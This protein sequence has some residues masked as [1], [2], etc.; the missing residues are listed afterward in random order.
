[1][2]FFAISDTHCAN[3]WPMPPLDDIALMIH[4]G[5]GTNSYD[6]FDS[7]LEMEYFLDRLSSIDIPH[8]VFV[9]GNHDR[10]VEFDYV[11]WKKRFKQAGCILLRDDACEIEGVKIY[12]S[13]WTPTF[14]NWA[15]MKSRTKINRIWEMIPE[16]TDILVTHGPPK[17]ILDRT[18]CFDTNKIISVGDGALAKRVKKV[19]PRFH[20]FGHVHSEPDCMNY[21]IYCEQQGLTTTYVNASVQTNNLRKKRNLGHVVNYASF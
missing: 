2:K 16:D 3:D 21:G 4:A 14:M 18:C 6:H 8:K 12:G 15:F 5:D 11:Y 7:R 10:C 1:M 9:P 17:G 13:P 19:N 20:V